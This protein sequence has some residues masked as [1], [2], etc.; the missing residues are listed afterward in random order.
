M[1]Q[2]PTLEALAEQICSSTKIITAYCLTTGHPQPSFDVDAPNVTLPPSAPQEVLSARQTIINASWKIRQLAIEPSEFLPYQATHYQTFACIHWLCH[3]GVLSIIPLHG[4]VTYS[5]V[6]MVAGVP[7]NQLK[8]IARMAMTGNFL[9]EPVPGQVSHNAT[10]SL[11]VT[12]PSING[13]ALFMAE[14]SC[15]GALAMVGATEK[16][17]VTDKKNETAFNVARNTDLPF[18]DYI[19]QHPEQGKQFAAYMKNVL[20]SEGT[21]VGHLVNGFDWASL[22]EATVVD[23]GGSRCHATIALASAFPQLKF[24]VQDLPETI[25]NAPGHLADLP[26]SVYSRIT[27]QAHN[28]FQPQPVK[29]A[30]V[31]LMRMIFHDWPDKEATAILQNILPALKTP[32][33]RLIIMDTVL[34]TPGSVPASEEALLRVRD[35]T[36]L[37]AFNSKER[38]LNDWEK[39]LSFACADATDGKL[40]LKSVTKPFG[41][42]MS[43]LEVVWQSNQTTEL[44]SLNGHVSG[45]GALEVNG[46]N[47]H[48]EVNGAGNFA[49]NGFQ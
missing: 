33:S 6:A 34:P 36:M 18:F 35:L 38:E 14:N 28:F 26:E 48:A 45:N 46:M 15:P 31:F 5:E 11:F 19:G 7:E 41:S 2:K 17:G 32:R 10:S 22:G 21:K 44:V 23:V 43:L 12:N 47:G 3:F 37:E 29:N 16:Y 25:A 8:S 40:T 49:V 30:D 39:L 13:W 27:C 9:S 20:A 1:C 42:V 4:S 24:I